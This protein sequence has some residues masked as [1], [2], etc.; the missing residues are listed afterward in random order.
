MLTVLV[1]VLEIAPALAFD[2]RPSQTAA[3]LHS[4]A[5]PAVH[6]RPDGFSV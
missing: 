1:A 3:V 5:Q 4:P 6:T 2:A